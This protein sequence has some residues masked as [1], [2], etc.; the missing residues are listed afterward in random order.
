[1]LVKYIRCCKLHLTLGYISTLLLTHSTTHPL[2]RYSPTLLHNQRIESFMGWYHA[3]GCPDVTDFPIK[4]LLK[5]QLSRLFHRKAPSK[6]DELTYRL[7]EEIMC[8]IATLLTDDL[9]TLKACSLTSRHWHDTVAPYIHHTLLLES[10]THKTLWGHLRRLPKS[11]RYGQS[12]MPH[13]RVIRVNAEGWFRRQIFNKRSLEFFSAFDNVHILE[14]KRLDIKSF[15]PDITRYFQ[16][17]SPT[18]RS[19]SLHDP[20]CYSPHELPYFLSHFPNLDD[21][22]IWQYDALSDVVIPGVELSPSPPKPRNWLRLDTFLSPKTLELMIHA[23]GGLRFHH[24]E[25]YS[26]RGSDVI[27]LRECADTVVTLKLDFLEL[28]PFD[29]SQLGI[30]EFLQ[31]SYISSRREAELVEQTVLTIRSPSFSKLFFFL[32]TKAKP[33]WEKIE[34]RIR[35]KFPSLVI[36]DNAYLSYRYPCQV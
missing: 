18:L 2:Y 33:H 31:I 28:E 7:P 19:I 26:S 14:I 29:L 22:N 30:L 13:V 5:D 23:L 25:L 15:M 21:I 34:R 36:N 17:F 35:A 6:P 9:K 16:Q 20:I 3:T 10:K 11:E 8:M 12:F 24:I 1:M 4:V 32:G 27:L